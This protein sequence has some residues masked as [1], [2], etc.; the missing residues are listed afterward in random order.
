[1]RK[2]Q[3]L[4]EHSFVFKDKLGTKKG[5]SKAAFF[6][7]SSTSNQGLVGASS[8]LPAAITIPAITAAAA[9]TATITPLPPPSLLSSFV[10]AARFAEAFAGA[11]A[12]A[13]LATT[14]ALISDAAARAAS[15]TLPKRIFLAPF[16]NVV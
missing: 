15:E 2:R 11:L 14:G 13:A 5:G 9:R 10:A 12:V 6:R 4:L 8:S 1:M 3:A 16:C 7:K